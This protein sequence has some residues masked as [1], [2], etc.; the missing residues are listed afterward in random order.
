MNAHVT[1][2]QASHCSFCAALLAELCP[3][4]NNPSNVQQLT[5]LRP[6]VGA[7][8]GGGGGGVVSGAGGGDMR[9]DFRRR[10]APLTCVQNNV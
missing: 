10:T 9:V 2:F 5:D 6:S 7:A 8:G 1:P 3:V 4:T